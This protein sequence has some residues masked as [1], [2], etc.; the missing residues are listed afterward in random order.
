[1]KNSLLGIS[2][3]GSI[4]LLVIKYTE[5]VTFFREIL[6]RQYFEVFF[7]FLILLPV[8][9]FSVVLVYKM[10]ERVFASWWNYARIAILAT[11]TI[12]LAISLDLLHSETAGSF[13][14][15]HFFNKMID[16]FFIGLVIFLFSLGSLIQIYRGHINSRGGLVK[17]F[18]FLVLLGIAIPVIV[19]QLLK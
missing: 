4:L 11:L 8:I 16:T 18:S 14:W 15:G 6:G 3:F 1:M 17:L 7:N 9:F 13:G 10:P 2:L 19:I 5:Y 12:F